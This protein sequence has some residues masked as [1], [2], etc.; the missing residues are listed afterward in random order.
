MQL[1]SLGCSIHSCSEVAVLR[2]I[3][4]SVSFWGSPDSIFCSISSSFVPRLAGEK[5]APAT[6]RGLA[7]VFVVVNEV[8]DEEDASDVLFPTPLF[9][10]ENIFLWNFSWTSL[11]AL[12]SSHFILGAVDN[13]FKVTL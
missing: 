12:D 10:E 1:A 5:I 3:R 4:W 8:P 13:S 7:V 11:A 9:Y 6:G 2:S